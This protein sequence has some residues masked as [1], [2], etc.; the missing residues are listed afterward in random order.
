MFEKLDGVIM[1]ALCLHGESMYCVS[2][3][4]TLMEYDLVSDDI[5]DTHTFRIN[6]LEVDV[7]CQQT[8]KFGEVGYK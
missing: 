5:L 4:I 3:E 6:D 2:I 8:F 7:L 1:Y